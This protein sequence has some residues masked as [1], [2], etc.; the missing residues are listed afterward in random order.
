MTASFLTWFFVLSF[1][2][3]S[4]SHNGPPKYGEITDLVNALDPHSGHTLVVDGAES[5]K[6]F[7]D[8]H[9]DWIEEIVPLKHIPGQR[10]VPD[11]ANPGQTKEVKGQYYFS[12]KVE[13]KGR[14]KKVSSNRIEG[15]F[16]HLKRYHRNHG[17]ISSPLTKSC[18][19][20]GG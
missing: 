6:N 9:A 3:Q 15:S 17:N 11:H 13:L 4:K 18:P 7:Q 5:Y 19:L 2:T 16:S 12:K 10:L 8:D 14:M 1:E 20:I